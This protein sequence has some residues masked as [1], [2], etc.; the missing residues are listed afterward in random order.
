MCGH[1]H[2]L[3]TAE[4]AVNVLNLLLHL[5]ILSKS[6][7]IAGKLLGHADGGVN[8]FSCLQYRKG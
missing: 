3:P 6:C 1:D 4:K 5:A 8:P 2:N 7:H